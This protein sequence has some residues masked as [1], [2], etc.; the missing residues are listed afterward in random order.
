MVLRMRES[1]VKKQFRIWK[2]AE[3]RWQFPRLFYIVF[4]EEMV[5]KSSIFTLYYWTNDC[6]DYFRF[7]LHLF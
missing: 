3:M 5:K 2:I 1:F 7:F 6:C 4:S